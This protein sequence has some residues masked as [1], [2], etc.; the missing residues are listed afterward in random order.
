MGW[1]YLAIAIVL[2]V[3]GTTAMKYSE[4]FTKLWPSVWMFVLYA[5]SFGALT[6]SIRT[7]ELSVAYAVWAG[8]GTALIAVVAILLFGAPVS[9]WKALSILLIIV[10]VVGLHLG[11]AEAAP[12]T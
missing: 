3:A 5:L 6:L 11:G 1:V 8:V 10:G 2:E 7:V 4:G 9:V 12:K